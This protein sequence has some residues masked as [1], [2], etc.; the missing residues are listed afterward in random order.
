VADFALLLHKEITDGTIESN[1]KGVGLGD[2]WI[3]PIDSV[4]TWAPFLLHMGAVDDKGYDAIM[5]AAKETEKLLNDGKGQESTDMWGYTEYVI[6]DVAHNVDFY[7]VM[8]KIPSGWRNSVRNGRNGFTEPIAK[9]GTRDFDD[10]KLE[11]IM[12]GAVK[13]A[14]GLENSW[15]VQSGK[16]F[17]MLEE[18]F[19]KPVIDVVETLLNTTD[20]K[21]F[22][23]TGQLDLIVDTPGTVVWVDNMNWIGSKKWKTAQR[24]PISYAGFY[25]GY[26][27]EVD[28]LGLYWVNRAG[29]MVPADNP[30]AMDFILRKLTNNYEGRKNSNH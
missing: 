22:V 15:G 23:F 29:H 12:N 25:E 26:R 3:S 8:K 7:N 4:L 16:T 20:I 30:W 14:L 9:P 2:S 11:K 17:Q 10:I 28:N 19:M 21:V 5:E 27:K 24:L 6:M 1:L 18:D 13:E